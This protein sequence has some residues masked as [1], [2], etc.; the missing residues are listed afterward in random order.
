MSWHS[1]THT[2]DGMGGERTWS[3][4]S[5]SKPSSKSSL[6]SSVLSS[7]HQLICDGLTLNKPV[8]LYDESFGNPANVIRISLAFHPAAGPLIG[9]DSMILLS[10]HCV[11]VPLW[12]RSS[13]VIVPVARGVCVIFSVFFCQWLMGLGDFMFLCLIVEHLF[14]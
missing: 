14:C 7:H 4:P 5:S 9:F 10:K 2:Q 13:C 12:H 8:V 3:S 1:H 11:C 6:K